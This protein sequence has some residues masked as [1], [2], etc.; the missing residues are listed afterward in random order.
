M[1]KPSD[2]IFRLIKSMTRTE[3]RYF[4]RFSSMHTS[5]EN[6]YIL[7]FDAINKMKEYNEEALIKKFKGESFVTNFSEI[8]K[9]LIAQVLKALRN[10]HGQ[11]DPFIQLQEIL[12]EIKLLARKGIFDA[13][14]S[15]IKRARKLAT[16][17]EA[18][19]VLM[20]L[21]T[22]QLNLAL[23]TNDRKYISQYVDTKAASQHDSLNKLENITF[24]RQFQMSSYLNH[25]SKGSFRVDTD[26]LIPD[27]EEHPLDSF[28]V[29]WMYYHAESLKVREA[30][31]LPEIYKNSKTCH[32][33]F[34]LYP[35]FTDV[36]PRN[37][38]IG[39]NHFV[40]VLRLTRRLDEGIAIIEKGLDFCKR[41]KKGQLLSE[42]DIFRYERG[43]WGNKMLIA[44]DNGLE[45]EAIVSYDY[46]KTIISIK[47]DTL[48][49]FLFDLYS[50]I[51]VEILLGRNSD[52]LAS[53]FEFNQVKKKGVRED[54][55][56]SVRLLAVLIH[57]E[58]KNYTLLENLIIS[59]AQFLRKKER[60]F[61]FEHMLLNFF[62]RKALTVNQ[63]NK[64][65]VN[66][67]LN[68]FKIE[69][70]KAF[71]GA[72][73][74]EDILLFFDFYTWIDSKLE[75]K[76]MLKVLKERYKTTQQNY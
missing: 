42:F 12:L 13:C 41:A 45:K 40:S 55:D 74:L 8:K 62:K 73:E 2:S 16:K 44:A 51:K 48:H 50:L 9:Y 65:Q 61:I 15:S 76:T 21:D 54:L 46:M 35:Q 70:D 59:T 14:L 22:Q 43:L 63:S 67:L 68:A 19:D 34:D 58:S 57:W 23:S 53:I 27:L 56:V 25:V 29:K 7:I 47:E 37:Y 30:N 75:Q 26:S 1:K 4:K 52:A 32:E 72:P 64:E 60:P 31:Y 66:E 49:G 18:F 20:E 33:L 6:K 71:K 28:K 5:G 17:Y 39:L 69:I 24:Y 38:I 3:K 10:Y 11:S 36:Y